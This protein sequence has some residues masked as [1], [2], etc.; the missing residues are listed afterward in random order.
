MDDFDKVLR[1][2]D[3]AERISIENIEKY[4]SENL[5]AYQEEQFRKHQEAIAKDYQDLQDTLFRYYNTEDEGHWFYHFVPYGIFRHGKKGL[6]EVLNYALPEAISKLKGETGL[7][8]LIVKI[9]RSLKFWDYDVCFAITSS[10]DS[11]FI[12]EFKDYTSARSVKIV[13]DYV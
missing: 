7:R 9:K 1:R 4:V 12:K 6:K 2:I 3:D 5:K 8:C 11:D 13:K 10:N